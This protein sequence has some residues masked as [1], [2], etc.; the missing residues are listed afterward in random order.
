MLWAGTGFSAT[1]WS[2]CMA[3]S[4][5]QLDFAF[6]FRAL[7][8]RHEWTCAPFLS[9]DNTIEVG[10]QRL[11]LLSF[12]IARAVCFF[13]VIKHFLSNTAIW[14]MFADYEWVLIEGRLG[15]SYMLR[16]VFRRHCLLTA[17]TSWNHIQV[18]FGHVF[19]RLG[20]SFSLTHGVCRLLF[21]AKLALYH[22]HAHHLPFALLLVLI[23]LLDQ[24]ISLTHCH[25]WPLPS[26]LTYCVTETKWIWIG[27]PHVFVFHAH[28]YISDW[29][30]NL[31][32]LL[33]FC[34][35]LARTG[36]HGR[37]HVILIGLVELRL[38]K[39]LACIYGLAFWGSTAYTLKIWLQVIRPELR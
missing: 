12:Q 16:V 36:Y 21:T 13:R 22:L 26:R 3:A 7:G 28:L 30:W 19:V 20:H 34:N 8:D 39:V 18:A 4:C 24:L 37:F 33:L 25:A 1:A 35:D 15:M 14:H 27:P 17:Q 6:F 10:S 31:L 23:L 2:R 29:H 32:N 11:R 9:W 5:D 38:I